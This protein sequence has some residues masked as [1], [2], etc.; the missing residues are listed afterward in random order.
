M[1]INWIQLQ[2]EK[3]AKRRKEIIKEVLTAI[4]IIIGFILIAGW[5]GKT[6]PY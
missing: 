4:L 1:R 6:F 3:K 2:R 5:A